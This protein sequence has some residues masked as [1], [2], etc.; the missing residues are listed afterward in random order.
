MNILL[1]GF[2]GAG[3]TSVGRKLAKRLGYRFI[4]TD[5]EIE[6]EQGCSVPDIFKY[7]GESC[8]RN[9]ETRLLEKLQ[10]QNNSIIAT[11]GGMVLRQENRELM[12]KIGKRVF[13]KVSVEELLLRL[14]Q[15]KQRP[16][17]QQK[18]PEELIQLMLKERT[19]IYEEAECIIDTS[20][21]SPQQ[22]VSE[23]IRSI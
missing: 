7:A 2:M 14:R 15:D 20:K 11:G 3:K 1:T 9:F 21:L 4:D 5:S 23:I 17:L 10:T 16:L 18:H 13:L 8:F 22:M 12:R 6:R 19:P